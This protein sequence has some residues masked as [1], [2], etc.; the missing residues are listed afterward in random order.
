VHWSPFTGHRLKARVRETWLRGKLIYDGA[1]VLS[2]PADGKFVRPLVAG[3]RPA[4][5]A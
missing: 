2:A 1:D 4:R 3:I 5:A